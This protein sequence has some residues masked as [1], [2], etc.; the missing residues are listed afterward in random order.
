MKI[1]RLNF[2]QIE[3]SVSRLAMFV[4]QG[5]NVKITYRLWIVGMMHHN[6]VILISIYKFAL[7][8]Q[9]I[10]HVSKYLEKPLVIRLSVLGK[11]E[12]A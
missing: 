11:M 1:Y 12:S 7:E 6:S 8:L 3:K 10:L 2:V 5:D 9:L 4:K